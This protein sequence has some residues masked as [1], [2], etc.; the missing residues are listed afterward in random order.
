MGVELQVI[1]RRAIIVLTLFA[2][3]AGFSV[4]PT[5]AIQTKQDR[6]HQLRRLDMEI[7]RLRQDITSLEGDEESTIRVIERLRIEYR[8]HTKEIERVGLEIISTEERI[9]ELNKETAVLSDSLESRQEQLGSILRRLYIS[10]RQGLLRA[11]LSVP[12]PQEVGLA[13]S[14]LA[15]IAGREMKF[16][17]QYR[18]DIGAL[19]RQQDDLNT[20]KADLENLRQSE[21]QHSREALR[22]EADQQ[23][24]LDQIR[25]KR[26]IYDKALQEK[27][28]ARENLKQLIKE[29]TSAESQVAALNFANARGR[30][31]WPCPGEVIATF[32]QIRDQVYDVVLENDGIDIKAPLGTPVNAVFDGK[33]VF[34]DWTDGRGNIVFLDHGSNYYSIYAHLDQFSVNLGDRVAAGQQIGN[35]GQT[36]SLKGAILHFEIRRHAD[37]L[38]PQRWLK[39]R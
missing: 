11:L 24:M 22:S 29:I 7:K 3:A 36:G 26:G 12:K 30:L 31:A 1:R 32:G 28:T 34:R 17:E 13:Q 23:R 18:A 16:V 15:A 35:V 5:V 39:R 25:S 8:I 33:V 4:F 6:E 14:Y 21:E 27:L 2:L 19:R 38:D 37:A 10:G 20:A 9:S